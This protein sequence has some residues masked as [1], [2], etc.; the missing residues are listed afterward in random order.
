MA[1]GARSVE[2]ALERTVFRRVRAT[3]RHPLAVALVVF[4][5]YG[6]SY[7]LSFTIQGQ[8]PLGLATIGPLFLQRGAASSSI[9]Q[10]S[11]Q[12]NAVAIPPHG[13]GYDGQFSFYIA[14]DPLHAAPYVDDPALRYGRILYPLAAYALALGNPT[15]IPY[16]LVI[17]NW[18]AMVFGTL[19]VA[20]WLRRRGMTPWLAL[21]FGLFPGLFSAFRHDLTEPLAFALTAWGVYALGWRR[22]LTRYV[23]ASVFFA[24]AALT[25]EVTLLVSIPYILRLAWPEAARLEWP[26]MRPGLVRAGSVLAGSLGP[27]LIWKLTLYTLFGA[28]IQD[29]TQY[30]PFR[31]PYAGIFAFWTQATA[32]GVESQV[33]FVALPGGIAAV[34]AIAALVKSPDGWKPATLALALNALYLCVFLAPQS[35]ANYLSAGRIQSGIVLAA[36]F[37]MPVLDRFWRHSRGWFWAACAL[38]LAPLWAVAVFPLINGYLVYLRLLPS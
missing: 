11:V 21:V 34:A 15:L 36:I 23:G 38:W 26:A 12:A 13:A 5:I 22:P 31:A 1:E 35:Y 32:Q 4:L 16:T 14:M 10:A 30:L 6:A 29:S 25:R 27:Y 18:L 7:W 24:L 3:L 37:A 8:N 19:G 33:L 20:L 9:I 28:V 2:R 17:V